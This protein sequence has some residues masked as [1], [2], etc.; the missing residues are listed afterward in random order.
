MG[1][2]RQTFCAKGHP[3]VGSNVVVNPNGSRRC[4]ICR[5]EKAKLRSRVIYA[6][7]YRSPFKEMGITPP[8]KRKVQPA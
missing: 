3:L 8:G 7:F 6:A 5:N 4:R 2:P 1:R